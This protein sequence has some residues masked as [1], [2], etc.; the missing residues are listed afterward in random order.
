[1]KIDF[2]NFFD[3]LLKMGHFNVPQI[4]PRDNWT[5]NEKQD[6]PVLNRMYNSNIRYTV[7]SIHA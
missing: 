3:Y 2:C 6:Y 5:N 4:S 7:Y 1:M